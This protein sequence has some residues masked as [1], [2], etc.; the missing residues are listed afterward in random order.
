M[1]C[2]D[3]QQVRNQKKKKK[4]ELEEAIRFGQRPSQGNTTAGSWKLKE[5]P[6][7]L[8]SQGGREAGW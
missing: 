5:D 6:S 8:W 2:R 3:L 4:K 1:Y 7:K